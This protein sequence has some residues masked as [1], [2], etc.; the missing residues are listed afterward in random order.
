MGNI[1]L[2]ISMSRQPT[3]NIKFY[4]L[5][6]DMQAQ[7]FLET[8]YESIAAEC[9]KEL[10]GFEVDVYSDFTRH[11]GLYTYVVW[12]LP[13]WAQLVTK[14]KISP[15]DALAVLNFSM[16]PLISVYKGQD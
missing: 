12:S 14:R 7:D 8:V 2:Y 11:N 1:S 6:P 3:P 10:E 15:E 9:K 5:G 13:V 4:I 16:L